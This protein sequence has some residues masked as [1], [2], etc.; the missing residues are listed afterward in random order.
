MTQRTPFFRTYEYIIAAYFLYTSALALALPLKPPV[1]AVTLVLNAAVLGGLVLLAYADALRR[2]Q[3]LSIVRDWYTPPLMLLAYREM[4]WFA[5][6]HVST[7]LEDG[8]VLWDRLL[9]NEWGLRSLV[10]VLGPVGPG[11]LE[12]AYIFVYPMLPMGIAALYLADRRERVP[13]FLFNFTLAVLA[14]YALFPYFPSEPPWT[15]YPGQDFPTYDTVFRR[16]NS[17][18]LRGQGIHTSVFPSAH[19]AG[20]MSAAFALIRL[21]PERIWVGRIWLVL[22]ILIAVATVYCRYHYAVDALAGLAIA[23]AASGVSAWR[24]RLAEGRLRGR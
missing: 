23:V 13:A 24:D 19:V 8:W 3:F 15:N 10:E 16:F 5:R 6:P 22:A 17:A 14:V 9:L 11:L 1:P 2:R 7:A 18:M 4:G 12:A 20:G 21:L